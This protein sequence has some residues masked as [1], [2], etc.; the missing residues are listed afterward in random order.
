MDAGVRSRLKNQEFC[1]AVDIVFHLSETFIRGEE[2]SQPQ[3][4]KD[5]FEEEVTKELRMAETVGTPF[6]EG[7]AVCFRRLLCGA[8]REQV[9]N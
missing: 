4:L 8:I 6:A 1:K 5:P 7:K 3:F 9:G 2:V